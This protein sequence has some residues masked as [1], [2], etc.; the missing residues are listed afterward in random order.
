MIESG[1]SLSPFSQRAAGVAIPLFSLRNAGDL[2]SGDILDL[3]PFIDWLA[4]WCH[5]VVQLLPINEAAPA[6][7]SPYTALSAFAIDPS[8]IAAARV[9]DIACSDAAQQWLRSPQVRRKR[10]RLEHSPQRERAAAYGFTLRLLEFGFAEFVAHADRERQARFDAFCALHAWWLDDYALFRA[11]KERRRFTSWETWPER[12]RFRDPAALAAAREQLHLRVRFAQYL[13]WIAAEQWAE[14]RAHA[15]R[16][17]VRIM[18]DLPFVC[19]RDS[20]DVWAHPELFD[21]SGSAGAPP[22]AFSPSGQAWGLPLYDWSALRRSGYEWWRQRVRHARQLYDLFRI[23]HVVGL[24]RTYAIPVHEGG[25]AGF[26]PRDEHDQFTQGH[27]LMSAIVAE[28]APSGVVAEDLGTVPDWVRHD[29]TQLG[30][31]GYRVFRWERHDHTF[32]DPRTYPALSI[33]T[34]GTHDTDSLLAWWDELDTSERAAIAHIL[35]LNSS[36]TTQHSPLPLLPL[37]RRLYEAGSSMTILPVQDIFGWP[38]R[39][40]VPATI[41]ADNWS[42]RLPA[43][44][45]QLDELPSVR[46]RMAS[47]REMIDAAA[48]APRRQ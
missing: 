21:F 41:S 34:S 7:A 24:Y 33:A 6:E 12:L 38:E 32:I 19:G 16:R 4:H 37:L 20:A 14:A 26:V 46:E 11:L 13:Q 31:P 5:T 23:D 22:D 10:E 9:A 39:I 1:T 42:Y 2:G 27:D 36:L 29:L 30:I 40:N 25:T 8:Y 3:I 28:A 15:R 18:G 48:R 43:A 44:I 35:E 45:D 47:V 17:G